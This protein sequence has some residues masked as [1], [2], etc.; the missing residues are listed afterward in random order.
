MRAVYTRTINDPILAAKVIGRWNKS[1]L[2]LLS[3][4]DQNT[5]V[6]LPFEE[7]SEFAALGRSLSNIAR[8]QYNFAEASH[9]GVLLTD[10]RYS[11]GGSGSIASVDASLLFWQNFWLEA[12]Y[13][14][15]MTEEPDDTTLTEDFNGDTFANGRYT[16]DFDGEKYDGS[17]L[18]LA[19][20]RHARHFNFDIKYQQKSPTYRAANGFIVQNDNKALTIESQYIFYSENNWLERIIPSIHIGKVYN[21]NN[22]LKDEWIGVGTF[23]RFKAQ[24]QFGAVFGF[25]NENFKGLAFKDMHRVYLDFNSN[26]SD[27]FRFGFFSKIGYFIGD[28]DE[29]VPVKSRGIEELRFWATIKPLHNL[30]FTPNLLFAYAI[31]DK[32]DEELYKGYILRIRTDF[33]FTRELAFRLILQYND[34]DKIFSIEPLLSYKI[35]PFSVFYLGASTTQ[36][37]Y[38]GSDW[39]GYG[40]PGWRSANQ[41][42]FVKFQYLFNI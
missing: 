21:F 25:N 30:L 40:Q 2:Y 23:F 20:K 33:Q 28:R 14:A 3:A 17:S 15:S 4:M 27:A 10:R 38:T 19:F 7:K 35:N 29:D 5:P 26:F 11:E 39:T 41:Q 8:F 34:F 32:T 22:E 18:Y 13:L 9:M 31:D 36:I 6:I 37:D 24:T 12:Q 1:T 16:S 42:L